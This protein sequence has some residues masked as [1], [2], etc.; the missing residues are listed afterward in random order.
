MENISNNISPSNENATQS[1]NPNTD[2]QQLKIT[3]VGD[4]M[5]GKTCMLATYTSKKFPSDYEPTMYV[6]KNKILRKTF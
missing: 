2:R 5:V 3:V 6:L 4:G 1:N